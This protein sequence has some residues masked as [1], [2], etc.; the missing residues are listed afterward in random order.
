MHGFPSLP[1]QLASTVSGYDLPLFFSLRSTFSSFSPLAWSGGLSEFPNIGLVSVFP[2]K[3]MVLLLLIPSPSPPIYLIRF[4]SLD[5]FR[6]MALPFL[7]QGDVIRRLPGILVGHFFHQPKSTER[8][9]LFQLPVSFFRDNRVYRT[10]TIT[11][12]SQVL[13]LPSPLW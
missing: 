13:L 1:L 2:E 7:R 8:R 11:S 10:P 4:F 9:P 3:T 12:A 6:D 5:F